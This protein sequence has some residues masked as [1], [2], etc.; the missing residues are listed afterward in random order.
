MVEWEYYSGGGTWEKDKGFGLAVGCVCG[1]SRTLERQQW[2]LERGMAFGGGRS[3]SG[4][5]GLPRWELV[6]KNLPAN[7]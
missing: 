7:P 4:S 5:S 6:V 1:L 2:Q 3:F